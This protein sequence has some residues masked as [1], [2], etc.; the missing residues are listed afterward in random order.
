MVRKLFLMTRTSF[1]VLFLFFFIFIIVLLFFLLLLFAYY[2]YYYYFSFSHEFSA[3]PRK[4][5]FS[6]E[7]PVFQR[8]CSYSTGTYHANNNP[9]FIILDPP[10]RVAKCIPKMIP[11]MI[12]TI[13]PTIIQKIM[14]KMTPKMIP[15]MVP[16]MG[17]KYGQKRKAQG[18]LSINKKLAARQRRPLFI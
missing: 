7:L 8:N 14:G 2:Y 1:F 17:P 3:F 6:N 16:K 18:H 12:H 15:K 10:K 11:K 4:L 5:C 9:H 13:I